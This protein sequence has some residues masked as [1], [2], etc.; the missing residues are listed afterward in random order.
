MPLPVA[1]MVIGKVTKQ[2]RRDERQKLGRLQDLIVKPG[3]LDKYHHH[4]NRFFD[5]SSA[6]E[7]DLSTSTDI[8]AAAAQYIEALWS[9]GFG[10]AEASYLLAAIQYMLPTLK[11]SLPLSWRLVK[12]WSKHELPTRAVPLDPATALSFAGLFWCWKEFRLAAGI[13]VAFDLFLRTGELFLLRRSDIEFFGNSASI[14]L[15]DTKS[16]HH[17]FHSQRLLAWD[18]ICVQALRLLCQGLAPGD[19]LIPQS[20]VKF[21]S[22]WH[23]AVPFFEL[24]DWYI[25]P[26]SLRRG[27]ATSAF[28]RGTSF[29]QLLLRGRWTHQRTARIYLDEALQQSSLLQFHPSAS[30]K[31]LWARHRL[32]HS[33]GL[34]P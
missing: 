33:F 28:R 13:V 3:T 31:L 30:R 2:Q 23:R 8:D 24:T 14:Q 12:A 17:Q 19:K 21:R 6:N 16:S 34:R 1:L 18:T 9:D 15:S 27:G 32:P 25:Q 26:Y 22:L 4:F 5:W 7:F 11:H 29:E 20:A 10:R